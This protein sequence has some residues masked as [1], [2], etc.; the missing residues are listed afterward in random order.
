MTQKDPKLL[1]QPGPQLRQEMTTPVVMRDVWY[2]LTPATL[3]GLWF[4][5]MGALLVL[6]TAIVG[7]GGVLISETLAKAMGIP[8]IVGKATGIT[9]ARYHPAH[10]TMTVKLLADP[11]SHKVIGAAFTGGDGVKERADFMAFAIRKETTL[12]ELA[13][14]ENVYSPAIGALGEP[15]AFAAINALNNATNK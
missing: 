9:A 15:I 14:M 12:E 1:I 11:E 6:L 4:F 13:T 10:E 8:C 2:A 5:G 7:V 3:A